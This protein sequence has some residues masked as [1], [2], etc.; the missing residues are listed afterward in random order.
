MKSELI[1]Q[2][3]VDKLCDLTGYT[4][5]YIKLIKLDFFYLEIGYTKENHV[6]GIRHRVFGDLDK[7][8]SALRNYYP[9]VGKTVKTH[10]REIYARPTGSVEVNKVSFE[11]DSWIAWE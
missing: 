10:S 1:R 3:Y 5:E 2:E 8:F 6:F 7:Y 4:V 9:S 11:D